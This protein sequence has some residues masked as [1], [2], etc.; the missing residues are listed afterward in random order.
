MGIVWGATKLFIMIK[1]TQVY[2]LPF[3][4]IT[5]NLAKLEGETENLEEWKESHKAF[6][7]NNEVGH[8]RNRNGATLGRC[9]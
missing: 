2:I 9:G 6:F 8:L 7:F 3:S 4:K 1:L 5:W